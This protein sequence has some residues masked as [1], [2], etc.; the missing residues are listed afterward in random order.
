MIKVFGRASGYPNTL[1]RSAALSPTDN[2]L[3]EIIN[4]FYEKSLTKSKASI[5]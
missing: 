2:P 3:I 4:E 1:S 5:Y